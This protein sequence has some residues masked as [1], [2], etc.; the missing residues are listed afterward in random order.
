M[1]TKHHHIVCMFAKTTLFEKE[2]DD[3]FII[4]KMGEEQTNKDGL[5]QVFDHT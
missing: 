4:E 1:P 2:T 3:S 5:L